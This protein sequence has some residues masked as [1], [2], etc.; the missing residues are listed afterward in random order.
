M[1]VPFLSIKDSYL[2]IS[3]EIDQA[4]SRSLNSGW[5][6]GGDEVQ[7]FES[8]FANYIGSQ[9]CV[10]LGNGLEAI[11]LSLKALG[12]GSGDEVIVPSHTFIAT[13][14]AVSNC[15]AKPIPVEVCKDTYSISLNEIEK[16]I[17]EKTKAIIPVH[18][19]GQP[20][21]LEPIIQ[22]ANQKNLFVIEDAAQAHGAIYNSKRVGSH[23]HVVAWSF[24]PGKNLGAFGDAGAITTNDSNLALKI[25]MLSNYGSKEKY[26]NTLQGFNSRL[27]PIQA[28]VLNIKL[29]YL[30]E[31]NQARKRI[32][33]KYL[34]NINHESVL[35]PHK[36]D[37][38]NCVWHLFPIRSKRRDELKEYLLK[39][40]IETLIHYPIPPHKQLAYEEEYGHIK[41]KFTETIADE[42]L[43]L[44]IGP[45]L[46]PEKVEYVID[47]INSF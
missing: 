5:Y 47:K 16:V 42:L 15:G 46:D 2:E 4:I 24:Y 43:S 18:L 23:G 33:S 25:K 35:I 17:T 36:F 22:L 12:V 9:C 32:A 38:D 41:L 30:D 39:N 8:S 40:G 27:D 44:P 14:L 1:K 3:E 21:D 6:I 28:S 37:Q 34:E 7:N 26:V 45:Q 20:V 11:H 31:W 29:N 10:G 19:Y 13:W